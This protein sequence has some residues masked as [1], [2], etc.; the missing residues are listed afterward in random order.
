MADT[1]NLDQKRARHAWALIEQVRGAD[2]KAKKEFKI[3]AKRL[4]ARIMAAGLGQ[5]L[6]FLEAKHYAPLLRAALADWINQ[7]A[8]G[9]A[10]GSGQDRLLL[11]VVRED[12]DFLRFATAEC[13]AY[14]QWV[15]RFTEAEFRD[16]PDDE[17]K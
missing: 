17:E 9:G 12:G 14:L 4:P 11:R 8:L 5:A 16:L 3:Q 1:P 13:L 2:D 6:A 7:H 10:K 15:V